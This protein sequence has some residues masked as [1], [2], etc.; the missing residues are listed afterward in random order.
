MIFGFHVMPNMASGEIASKSGVIMAGT[1]RFDITITGRGGHAAAPHLNIDPW[2]PT[3][4][5]ILSL[6]V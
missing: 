2:M 4:L 3:S 6:Q 1:N 5:L